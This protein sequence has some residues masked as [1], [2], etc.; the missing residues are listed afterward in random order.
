MAR[1]PDIERFHYRNLNKVKVKG[2][3]NYITV[4]EVFEADDE[5]TH[6]LNNMGNKDSKEK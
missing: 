6:N 3:Q 1:I 2:N 5:V 4:V